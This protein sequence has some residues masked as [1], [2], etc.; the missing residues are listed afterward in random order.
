MIVK[1]E[2]SRNSEYGESARKSMEK[3]RGMNVKWNITIDQGEICYDNG[4]RKKKEKSR[5]SK[6][7]FKPSH[8]MAHVFDERVE[9]RAA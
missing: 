8:P 3:S 6:G 9:C 4:N 7:G 5:R 2:V 1:C